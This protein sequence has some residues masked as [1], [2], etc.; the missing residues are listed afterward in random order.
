MRDL[1]YLLT[2]TPAMS[3][4]TQWKSGIRQ[5]L[6]EIDSFFATLPSTGAGQ[7]VTS[8]SLALKYQRHLCDALSLYLVGTLQPSCLKITYVGERRLGNVL[9]CLT[10]KECLMTSDEDIRKSQKSCQRVVL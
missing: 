9:Q 5:A 7:S 8:R 2:S 4:G 10:R 6:V 3:L 1:S